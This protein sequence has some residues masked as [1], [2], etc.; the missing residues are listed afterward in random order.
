MMNRSTVLCAALFCLILIAAAALNAMWI[1]NGI[2][3]AGADGGQDYSRIISDGA[4]G[5]LIVWQDYNNETTVRD[6]YIQRVDGSGVPLWT[7]CGVPLCTET[8]EQ[9]S[10]RL[11]PDGGGGAIAIWH[12]GR[13][14]DIDIYA[15][16]IKAGGAIQWT[17]NGI[18]ICAAA[19]N[20]SASWIISDGAGGA[21][22]VWNDFRTM[23]DYDIYIQHLNDAGKRSWTAD[24]IAVCTAPGDQMLPALASDG[25]GGVIVCWQDG[26]GATNAIF[27][28]R[29]NASGAMQWTAVGVAVC[30]ASGA[31]E[32]PRMVSDGSD[33]VIV[34]WE[35]HRGGASADIYGQ[36]INA[37]G[38]RLWTDDGAAICTYSGDQ[39][40]VEIATDG[41]GGAIAVWEDYKASAPDIFAQRVDG[42][43]ISLWETDGV[44]IGNT[45]EYQ[46]QPDIAPNSTGGA[47]ITWVDE[48]SGEENI[49]AQIVD[50][51]GTV[52]WTANG[53][54]IGG[55]PGN[56][57]NPRAVSDGAGGGIF[58]WTDNS[59]QYSNIHAQ[60]VDSL[61]LIGYVPHTISS[62]SDL[63]GDEGGAVRIAV[64]RTSY[65]DGGW[66]SYPVS[67]YNVWR[68]VDTPLAS[69]GRSGSIEDVPAFSLEHAPP[70][71]SEV[72]NPAAGILTGFEAVHPSVPDVDLREFLASAEFPPG[73]WEIVGSFGS[74]QLDEYIYVTCTTR[75][76]T[77]AGVPWNVYLVSAHTTT[78][79][80]WFLCG[81][82][83]GYS[84]DNIAPAAPVG[85]SGTPIAGP[86]GVTLSWDPNTE[87]DLSFYIV[88]RGSSPG[89]IPSRFT[90]IG[91]TAEPGITDEYDLWHESYYKIFAVDR[92]GNAGPYASIGPNEL[93]DADLPDAPPAA[94][95]D[96]NYPNPFNP[97]TTIL[98]GLSRDSHVSLKVYDISGRL[99][100]VIAD[101]VRPAGR[102]SERWDGLTSRGRK[103]ASG[104]YYYRLVSG[105]F[106]E[107]RKMI[108]L[109]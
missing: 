84:V 12:D 20:Q 108:L 9:M 54:L 33:G 2:P 88:H 48:R 4:G 78:P 29:I 93:S 85:L 57:E 106:D 56:D 104:I 64:D 109:R 42:S 86:P 73:T 45:A 63:P 28:Q 15:Q 8:G 46:T 49:Y 71:V 16:R 100:R 94:Y 31:Q 40:D 91:Q 35:D 68:R 66:Y 58:S 101:G 59:A 65:D 22:I 51:S 25:A 14:S 102:Y 55:A 74:C 23:A 24:G 43:G 21:F 103:A 1:E 89:F 61:C 60:H 30:T 80:M 11:A 41:S 83:S 7:P 17:S 34:V 69:E 13:G 87:N 95:L 53:L 90:E 81:P 79:S 96:Q 75:D 27:A 107:T 32:A 99:V 44:S 98:F 38:A 37:S 72:P 18:A 36:R 82:D 76:S 5:A 77:S 47:I 52:Q 39:V 92:H 3:L 105:E 70:A 6:I 50:G 62:V 67:L 19:G 10:P 97:S 26:R